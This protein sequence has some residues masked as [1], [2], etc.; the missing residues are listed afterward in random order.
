MSSAFVTRVEPGVVAILRGVRH[1]GF[2]TDQQDEIPPG[3][4]YMGWTFEE[5]A[6]RGEGEIQVPK[7]AKEA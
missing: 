2:L 3:G 7:P 1:R 6:A 5:L 4:T